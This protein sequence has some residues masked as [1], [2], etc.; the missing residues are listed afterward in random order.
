MN[1]LLGVAAML[2]GLAGLFEG[3]ALL[4]ARKYN[5]TESVQDIGRKQAYEDAALEI[6]QLA[7]KLRAA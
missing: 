3:R 7:A 5:A 6:R 4:A 1:D 2:D